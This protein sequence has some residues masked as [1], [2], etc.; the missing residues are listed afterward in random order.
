MVHEKKQNQSRYFLRRKTN[1][2]V[3]EYYHGSGTQCI[4]TPDERVYINWTRYLDEA[5]GFKTLKAAKAMA[6]MLWDMYGQSVYV[7]DRYGGEVF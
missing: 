5:R 6:G 4:G 2:Y 3:R 1:G 7:V